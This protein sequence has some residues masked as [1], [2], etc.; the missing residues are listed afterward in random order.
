MQGKFDSFTLKN[1]IPF[2]TEEERDRITE[3]NALELVKDLN[4]VYKQYKPLHVTRICHRIENHRQQMMRLFDCIPP[5]T[6]YWEFPKGKPRK[7]EHHVMTAFREFEEETRIPMDFLRILDIPPLVEKVTGSDGNTYTYVFY[8]CL[9]PELNPPPYV[10][11]NCIRPVTI[12]PEILEL[13][14][15]EIDE[16]N[17]KLPKSKSD[18]LIEVMKKIS[19]I[20]NKKL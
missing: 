10:I 5:A 3:Y 8:V 12:S 20:D 18:L 11:E 16:C 15:C 1:W 9:C 6:P 19:K 17:S 13:K 14:W 2:L 7:Y 4:V